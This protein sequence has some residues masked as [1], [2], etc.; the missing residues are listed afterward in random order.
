MDVIDEFI[1]GLRA[2]TPTNLTL[3]KT[4]FSDAPGCA[5]FSTVLSQAPA[6]DDNDTA[7]DDSLGST[8]DIDISEHELTYK[9]CVVE[10]NVTAEESVEVVA[11]SDDDDH[12][13]KP[14]GGNDSEASRERKHHLRIEASLSLR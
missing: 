8:D 14:W 5:T 6:A 13:D 4:L 11:S 2:S 1:E 7:D 3:S 12:D 9:P 10:S